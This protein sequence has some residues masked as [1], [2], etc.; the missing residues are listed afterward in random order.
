M[1]KIKICGLS[2]HQDIEAA[3]KLMPDYIGFIFA[4]G[5][6]QIKE[7]T[8]KE[9][10]EALDDKIKAVGVFVN[11]DVEYIVSLCNQNIIDMIQIHGDEDEDYL[12][13][14]KS[15]T[16]KPLIRAFRIRS[17]EDIKMAEKCCADYILL[18]SYV[19][20]SYGGSGHSFSWSIAKELQRNYFLAG[21]IHAGNV[22]EA[23]KDNRP[24]CI[25]ISSGVETN[26]T[27]DQAKMREVIGIIRRT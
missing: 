13:N 8:A 2:S 22:M 12:R 17:S 1:T 7:T 6:R 24:Y 10:K 16:N 20:G 15:K 11:E 21:G 27:K 19:E 5:I 3:N 25:D 18:D 26:G 23:V 9:L 4:K 14:L